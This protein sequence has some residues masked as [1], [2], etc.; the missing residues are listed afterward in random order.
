MKVMNMWAD[1]RV[2]IP[3][4]VELTTSDV[5]AN[6]V[7]LA[8]A[9]VTFPIGECKCVLSVYET[10]MMIMILN[11][12]DDDGDRHDGNDDN[13]DNSDDNILCLLCI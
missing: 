8:D 9:G 6:K 11:Y 12:K 1:S 5:E 10:V 4:F 7:K 2:I 13:D 3:T